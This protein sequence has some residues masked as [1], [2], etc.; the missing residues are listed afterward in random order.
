MAKVVECKGNSEKMYKLQ[1]RH[2]F[3]E[4]WYRTGDLMPYGQNSDVQMR[5][6]VI[7]LREA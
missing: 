3:I 6:A 7:S 4:G 1:C 5:E 2:G